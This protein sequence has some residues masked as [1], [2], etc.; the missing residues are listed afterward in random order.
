MPL[1]PAQTGRIAKVCHAIL[2]AGEVPLT[3]IARFMKEE[4]QQDS[5]VRSIKRLLEA[6]FLTQERVYQPLLKQ[7]LLSFHAKTWHLVMDRTALWEGVDLATISLNYHKRAVPLV[8]CCVPYGGA[9]EATYIQLLQRCVPLV[10]PP[11]QVIFQGDTEFGHSGIMRTLREIGWDFI[12]AQPS[13]CVFR[14]SI[15]ADGV[16]LVRLPVTPHHNCQVAQ[17]ELFA[18]QRLASINILAF[19][20]P[21]SS[22][23]HRDRGDI[24]YLATSLPL[25]PTLRRL[26][27]RRWGTEPFYRDYKSSGWSVTV[28]QLG[29]SQRQEGLLILL[30]LNYLWTVCIGRWLCKTGQ[31][32]Q[33][34]S[35]PIRHLSLFRIGWDW[36]IHQLRC[37]LPAPPFLRLYT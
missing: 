7:A 24:C 4:T 19:Y 33:V 1:S 18:Q 3:K 31:R 16:P 13:H 36:L 12:L 22:P 6:D 35:Q 20:Q 17:V 26:G 8:W 25:T 5:R 14:P 15:H 23:L 32:R 28:S 29:T 11:V 34:D 30:A 27:R 21:H 37:D 9:P 2:L 10:P